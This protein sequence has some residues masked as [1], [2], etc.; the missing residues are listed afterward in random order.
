MVGTGH[1]GTFAYLAGGGD[2]AMARKPKGFR[3]VHRAK[4]TAM[5]RKPKGFRLGHRVGTAAMARKPKGLRLGHRAGTAAMVRKPKGFRLGQSVRSRSLQWASVWSGTGCIIWV[6]ASCQ[7]FTAH[8]SISNYGANAPVRLVGQTRA[9]WFGV[10]TIAT[11]RARDWP[12]QRRGGA[13]QLYPGLTTLQIS[14]T[15][16]QYSK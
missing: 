9:R 13:V 15:L 3:L 4:T 14:G 16:R 1:A 11:N 10:G 12:Q 5:A 7:P 6:G 2:R 8:P